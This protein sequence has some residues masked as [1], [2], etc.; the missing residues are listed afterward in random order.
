MP[1]KHTVVVSLDEETEKILNEVGGN[2]S[3]WIREAIRRRVAPAGDA[4]L[5]QA[6]ADA[7]G[8]RIDSLRRALDRILYCMDQF[9][10]KRM[11]TENTRQ[12][13]AMA[14]EA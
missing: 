13:M 4:E 9:E 10:D 6:L 11:L 2:R 8:R 12:A 14:R 1:S 3:E 7:R 5:L